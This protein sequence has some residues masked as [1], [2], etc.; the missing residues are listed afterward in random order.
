MQRTNQSRKSKKTG[1]RSR[2]TGYRKLNQKSRTKSRTKSKTRYLGGGSYNGPSTSD[3]PLLD[4]IANTWYNVHGFQ[5]WW[6]DNQDGYYFTNAKNNY[7]S[8]THTHIFKASASRN[9]FVISYARKIENVQ[10]CTGT[11]SAIGM[12]GVIEK[13]YNLNQ[14]YDGNNCN[15]I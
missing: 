15:N 7:M 8:K 2:I 5:C 13:I 12:D 6:S 9:L 4:N 11:V 1:G 14:V 10:I 3:N